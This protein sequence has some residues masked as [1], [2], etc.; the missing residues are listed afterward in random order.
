MTYMICRNRVEDYDNWYGIFASHKKAHKA[1]GMDLV[2]LWRDQ[3]DA[4]NV[5][6]IYRV[7][8]VEKVHEFMSQPQ[9]GE[10]RDAA[11]VIDGEYSFVDAE[12]LY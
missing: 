12:P 9:A 10:A 7:E 4:N 11:R 5:F 3:A 1:H 2:H 6:F 8:S